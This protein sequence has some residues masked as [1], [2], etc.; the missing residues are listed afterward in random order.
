MVLDRE[1]LAKGPALSFSYTE[2]EQVLEAARNDEDVRQATIAKLK[3]LVT[4]A[5][6]KQAYTMRN[7]TISAK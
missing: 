7:T 4:F 3:T 1:S 6:T 2:L 5:R